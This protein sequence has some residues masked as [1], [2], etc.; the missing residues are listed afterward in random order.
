MTQQICSVCLTRKI[1][2]RYEDRRGNIYC[3]HKF[4]EYT[5]MINRRFCLDCQKKEEQFDSFLFDQ[6]CFCIHKYY[7]EILQKPYKVEEKNNMALVLEENNLL[8]Q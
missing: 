1:K 4:M 2:Q 6:H 5:T 7:S 3:K 8:G